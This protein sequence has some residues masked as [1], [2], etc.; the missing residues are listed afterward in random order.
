MNLR[1]R[2]Y[3]AFTAHLLDRRLVPGQFVT[4]R[5]LA[6][7]TGMPLG[8]I[9]EMIPRLEAEGLLRR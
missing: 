6:E 5:E 2:A 1:E 4:Q 9:R 3:N 7:L 8:A